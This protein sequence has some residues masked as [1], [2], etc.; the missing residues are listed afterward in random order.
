MQIQIRYITSILIALL[1]LSAKA[2]QYKTYKN[3]AYDTIQG[4][5]PNLLSLDVYVPES[6]PNKMAVIL[7]VHGGAWCIGDKANLQDKVEFFTRE[8]FVFISANYRL[9]PFPYDTLDANAIRHPKHTR[10]IARAIRFVKNNIAK[11][12]GN[13]KQI[14]LMGHSAGAHII[15]LVS[16]HERF[17][18]NQG[19]ATEDVKC[20]CTLDQGLFNVKEDLLTATDSRKHMLINAFTSDPTIQIDASPDLQLDADDYLPSF[21]LVHQ[22][23]RNRIRLNELFRDRINDLGGRAQSFNAFPYD[24]GETNQN[25]G[26]PLDSIGL[27]STI[28]NFFNQCRLTSPIS[29]TVEHPFSV[30]PNPTNGSIFISARGDEKAELYNANGC[31]FREIPLR[32]QT[33]LNLPDG[34]YVLRLQSAE[35][36]FITKLII[37]K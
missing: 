36:N 10:D 3:V 9:S 30:Y 32:T 5:N 24:H 14:F 28:L 17:M 2:Q 4:V 18:Q 29:N 31:F 19:L 15:N 33:P 13:P 6:G 12:G 35:S 1:C 21:L 34:I 23:T 27:S 25:I 16:I 37:K 11:Y 7:F 8:N 22:G 20:V 26:D